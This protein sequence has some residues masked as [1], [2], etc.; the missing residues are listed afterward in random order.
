MA[1]KEDICLVCKEILAQAGPFSKGK[2][3][4]VG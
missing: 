3:S 1:I 2:I 4:L